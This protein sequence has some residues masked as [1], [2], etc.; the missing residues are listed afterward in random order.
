MQQLTPASR[1][2][3]D[4]SKVVEYLLSI[5]NGHGKATFFLGF[6]FQPDAWEVMAKAIKQ[7][8]QGNPVA[9]AVDSLTV[10]ATVS[11]E[12]WRHRAAGVR[13]CGLSGYVK[14]IPKSCG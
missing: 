3:V 8:A 4:K 7:Q 1:L 13:K 11:T 14:P 10:P 12:S 5:S 9:T 6:G 2:R